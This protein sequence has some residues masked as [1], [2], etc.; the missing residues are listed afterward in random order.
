ML[1][2]FQNSHVFQVTRSGCVRGFTHACGCR[3]CLSLNKV[4]NFLRQCFMLFCDVNTNLC[5]QIM[6][7]LVIEVIFMSM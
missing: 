5:F 3:L 4:V 2:F 6:K 1:T 7:C